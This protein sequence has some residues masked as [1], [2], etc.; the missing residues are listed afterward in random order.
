MRKRTQ[1]VGFEFGY[2]KHVQY[3][4]EFIDNALDAIESFQWEELQKTDSKIKFSLDQD[5]F[6]EKFSIFEAAKEEEKDSTLR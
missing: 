6:L 2:W 4:A 5:L 1:L 3:C